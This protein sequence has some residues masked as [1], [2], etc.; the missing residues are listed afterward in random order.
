MLAPSPAWVLAL[1][2]L[3]TTQPQ[4]QMVSSFPWTELSYPP[5]PGVTFKLV[6][7]MAAPILRYAPNALVTTE[8]MDE[9]NAMKK[10]AFAAEA[11]AAALKETLK[12]SGV[13]GRGESNG[14]VLRKGA[15]PK[16][17]IKRKKRRQEKA[18]HAVHMIKLILGSDL[19]SAIDEVVQSAARENPSV[20]ERLKE[21]GGIPRN[22]VPVPDARYKKG[23]REIEDSV[24]GVRN[25]SIWVA[26]A[27]VTQSAQKSLK[28]LGGKSLITSHAGVTKWLM[29]QPELPEIALL[30]SGHCAVYTPPVKLMET[31]LSNPIIT[32]NIRRI[33]PYHPGCMFVWFMVRSLIFLVSIACKPAVSLI[34]CS[35]VGIK[36]SF[37]CHVILRCVER[38]VYLSVSTG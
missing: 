35:L 27:G 11:E 6:A 25:T 3:A 34:K 15:P 23:Y 26:T 29:Y 19:S 20:L 36:C 8:I 31:L 37:D 28:K 14:L 18:K 32:D 5:I 21:S 12:N 10:R 16:G 17:T 38:F 24:V 1:P 33:K 4:A 7:L 2:R 22:L 13:I 9:Y 30:P